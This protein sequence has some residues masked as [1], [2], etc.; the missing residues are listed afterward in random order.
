CG[1]QAAEAKAR[2]LQPL[3]VDEATWK[4]YLAQRQS[5][6]RVRV[7]VPEFV[8]VEAG[9]AQRSRPHEQEAIRARLS[10]YVGRPLDTARLETDLTA[11]TGSGRYA[12]V[13][14]GMIRDGERN[15][16]LITA[17]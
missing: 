1:Y 3:S 11:L 5:R 17:T 14:Y 4:A 2:F 15:G 13:T 10:D 9:T 7:D 8:R 16:L 12:S 6:K